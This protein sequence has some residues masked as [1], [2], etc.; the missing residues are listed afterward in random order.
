LF[1]RSFGSL[2]HSALC[3][4]GPQSFIATGGALIAGQFR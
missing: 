3:T 4:L 1:S 2:L